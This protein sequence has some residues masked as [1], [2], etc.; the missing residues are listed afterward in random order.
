VTL[1]ARK[2]G[3]YFLILYSINRSWASSQSE[4]SFLIKPKINLK[5]NQS[6]IGKCIFL[7][8]H[9]LDIDNS[10]EKLI[11]FELKLNNS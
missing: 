10:C 5:K 2:K 1:S 3:L 11:V 9:F 4:T 7:N 6:L 8:N